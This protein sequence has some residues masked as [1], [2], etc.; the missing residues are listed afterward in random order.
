MSTLEIYCTQYS[1]PK[2]ARFAGPTIEAESW[3]AAQTIADQI[4][5]LERKMTQPRFYALTVVGKNEEVVPIKYHH[6]IRV[7]NANFSIDVIVTLACG[8]QINI[9][10]QS[11]N[12]AM[13]L[14]LA[15]MHCSENGIA[16]VKLECLPPKEIA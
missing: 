3:D 16:A 13:A 1:D 10:T 8:N 6:S 15:A 9:E 12:S 14:V 7:T 2:G 4:A 11:P 5:K